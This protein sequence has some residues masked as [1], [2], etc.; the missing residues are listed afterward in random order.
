[1]KAWM[2]TMSKLGSVD[3]LSDSDDEPMRER[4]ISGFKRPRA[5]RRGIAGSPVSL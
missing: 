4:L 5:R 1:M 3:V 2:E